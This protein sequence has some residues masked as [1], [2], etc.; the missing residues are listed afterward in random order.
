MALEDD[1]VMAE[2]NVFLSQEL[3]NHLYLLQYP[4]RPPWRGYDMKQMKEVRYKP[5]S[6]KL[7]MDFRRS[8]EEMQNHFDETHPNGR[9]KTTL[10]SNVVLAKT[11]YAIGVFRDGQLHITPVRG[12][13]Q[14]RPSFRYIDE[15]DAQKK[16]E[17]GEM[18]LDQE[19]EQDTKVQVRFKRRETAR[20]KAARERSHH[21]LKQQEEEEPWATLQFIDPQAYEEE[22]ARIYNKLF[23]SSRKSST[24]DLS[25]SAYL[26][27]IAPSKPPESDPHGAASTTAFSLSEAR[28]LP[29]QRQVSALFA[30]GFI[31]HF[32]HV[33]E[34]VT[35]KHAPSE[36]EVLSAVELAAVLV[37]GR[38]VVRSEVLSN[39]PKM[40]R[41]RD[42]MLL[43]FQEQG[44]VQRVDFVQRTNTSSETAREML[45]QIGKL[46]LNRGWEL[47]LDPDEYFMTAY[48][49]VVEKHNQYW[50]DKRNTILK[51]LQLG[52][53]GND[54]M[55]V[56][57][58]GLT[59][60]RG[61]TAQAKPITT[62]NNN[63]DASGAVAARF[64]TFL[65]DLFEEHGVCNSLF[66]RQQLSQQ[67][68]TL[69]NKGV[70]EQVFTSVLTSVAR[71]LHSAYFRKK[72]GDPKV[73]KFRDIIVD[74]VFSNGVATRKSHVMNAVKA[75][76]KES[77]DEEQLNDRIY[78]L[79]MN[80][81][82]YRDNTTW[83][84]KNGTGKD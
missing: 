25:P 46:N 3:S 74:R 56:E 11:N 39:D 78:G 29:L 79:I 4:L 8:K 31:L 5:Q 70:P 64:K 1:E 77:G 53:A 47:K 27:T 52:L 80:E 60:S 24:F 18:A 45:S 30:N 22:N 54:Q 49:D 17:S 34:L 13:F 44:V 42:Y 67:P 15:A 51:N 55:E 23:A 83:I 82:A 32:K 62:S 2:Y 71:S 36:T 41:V 57:G 76:Q 63:Q 75:A 72:V 35:A 84:F 10:T 61:G 38:W 37:D 43:E 68:D 19:A 21:F 16:K 65:L 50:I 69:L 81:L 9:K 26:H 7:E 33:C 14:M 28:K 58:G 6:E 20:A 12:L 59:L 66:I 40:I 73:D 48:P